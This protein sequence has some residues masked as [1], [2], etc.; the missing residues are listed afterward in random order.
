MKV[1]NQMCVSEK[2]LSLHCE[3]T[4]KGERAEAGKQIT[5]DIILERNDGLN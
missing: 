2:S 5:V 4:N 1:N 3:D